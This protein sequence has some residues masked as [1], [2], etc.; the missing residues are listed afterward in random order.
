MLICDE[1]VMLNN[2][3]TG[4]SYCREIVKRLFYNREI[5]NTKD[6]LLYAL[7]I[8]RSKLKELKLKNL[9]VPSRPINQHG[10]FIQIPEEHRD[11]VV[12]SVTR[13]P[14]S[15]FVSGYQFKFWQKHPAVP[16]RELQQILP[17]YPNLSIDEYVDLSK[18]TALKRTDNN[19]FNIGLQTVQFV[20]MFFK[21][22]LIALA[23]LNDEYI[24]SKSY[25]SDMADITFLRQENLKDDLYQF[26]KTCG[27]TKEE[28]SIIHTSDQVNKTKLTDDQQNSTWTSKAI[29]YVEEQERYLIQILEDMGHLVLKPKV[30]DPL[31]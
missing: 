26:L 5:H 7:R 29:Q 10:T 3:K 15:K 17:S 27:F 6:K 9:Y 12:V 20:Q 25:Q 1:F 11:K 23:K 30:G 18:L 19:D 28:L 14:Y 4:S 8:K 31:R 16:K 22:P 13:N 21:E 2:P 24:S